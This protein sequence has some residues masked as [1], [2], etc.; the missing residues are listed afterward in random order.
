MSG[1]RAIA[2]VTAALTNLL[3]NGLIDHDVAGMTGNVTVSA[4]APGA[5][6]LDSIDNVQINL[7]MYMV[8]PNAAWRNAALP[9]R[10]SQGNRLTNPP[11]ALNL[12]YMLTAYGKDDFQAELLLGYAMQ[13]L[14]AS[15]ASDRDRLG[16]A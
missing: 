12:H 5:I 1:P 10:D 16:C 6:K 4:R 11:L 8:T 14:H 15:V 13:L 3:D 9:V 2:A 7:F